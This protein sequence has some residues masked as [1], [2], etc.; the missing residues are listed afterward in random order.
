VNIRKPSSRIL[1]IIA[2][3]VAVSASGYSARTAAAQVLY[4]SIVGTLTDQTG[5]VVPKATVTVTNTATGLSRQ[6]TTNADGYYSI[7]N[8]Q[9]GTYDL[10]ISAAGFRTHTQRG[11]NVPINAATRIDAVISVGAL[12]EEVSVEG[13]AAL[14]QTTRSDV[15]TSLDT[16]AIE[17]LPLS[18]YR[19]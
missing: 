10:S 18:N 4:G 16:H 7:P 12:A 5:A 19:N 15:S 6:A 14:L 17:N 3:A 1:A 9:E 13:S 11:V 8:L 2:C